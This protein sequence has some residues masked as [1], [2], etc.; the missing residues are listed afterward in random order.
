MALLAELAFFHPVFQVSMSKKCLS[1]PTSILP[2]EGLGVDDDLSYKD[3]FVM[4][5][6]R[7]IKQLRNKEMCTVKV[8]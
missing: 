6:D 5:F 3:V 2:V 7:Q 4:I 1:D 8:L